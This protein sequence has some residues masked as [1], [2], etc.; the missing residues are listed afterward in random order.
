LAQIRQ[1]KCNNKVCNEKFGEITHISIT[2]LPYMQIIYDFSC[3]LINDPG[4]PLSKYIT[5]FMLNI[6]ILYEIYAA[7]YFFNKKYFITKF[8]HKNEVFMYDGMVKNRIPVRLDSRND[9]SL[10]EKQ[11]EYIGSLECF[12]IMLF[13]RKCLTQQ[14][15]IAKIYFFKIII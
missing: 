9:L 3:R 2:I 14:F 1:H 13:F 8:L 5:I 4:I 6:P 7:I 15:E 12:P 10:L 11:I